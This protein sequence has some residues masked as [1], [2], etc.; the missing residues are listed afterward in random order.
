MSGR[1]FG[2][3]VFT[4]IW[5]L[6]GYLVF[7]VHLIWRPF[8][9]TFWVSCLYGTPY[10]K[11][12]L[13]A[14]LDILSLWYILSEGPSWRLSGYLAFMVHLIW[15]PFL[16]T[17]WVSCLYCTPYLKAF[18][19]DFLGILSLWY[20]LYEGLSWRLSGYHVFMVHLIWRPFLTPYWVSCLYGTSYPKAFPD[21]FLGILSLWYILSESLSWRLSGCLVSMVH[22]I[23]RP[24]VTTFW[25]SCLYGTLYLKTFLDAFLGVLSW[26]YTLFYQKFWWFSGHLVFMVHLN[27][28]LS[29]RLT[30]FWGS[31]L[32]GA[33]YC[34]KY[35][36]RLSGHVVT[37]RP[38]WNPS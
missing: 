1:L 2:R 16:T 3:L 15:R 11:A 32:D 5:R 17:F 14:F 7:M 27:W 10:L 34:K 18:L 6:S 36:R 33:P 9:T 12:F 35:S 37:W 25:V 13:D 4:P 28:R 29:W 22:L 21:A 19:D 38:F 23:W 26:W 20:T 24:F 31:C 30:P 8:L